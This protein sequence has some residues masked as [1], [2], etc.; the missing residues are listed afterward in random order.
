MT[1]KVPTAWNGAIVRTWL[2]RRVAASRLDQAVAQRG[3]RSQQD[4]CD[5]ATAEEIVC[6]MLLGKQSTDDQKA[7]AADLRAL[8]DRN[9]YPA[10]GVYDDVRFDRHVRGYIRKLARMTKT[11]DGFEKTGRY[12]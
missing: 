5:K 1:D 3:D 6:T 12:Q 10:R 7:F 11:N 9:D 2:E 8:L 4:D